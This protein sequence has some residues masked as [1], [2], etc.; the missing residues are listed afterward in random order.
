M[1]SV[2]NTLNNALKEL[3]DWSSKNNLVCHPKKCKA[4]MLLRGSFPGPI[5]ALT[6][7]NHTIKW[8]THARLLGLTIDDKLTRT[9]HISEAKKSFLTN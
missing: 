6:L 2:T 1:D 8:V 4:M 5:H 9:Q 7:C 3:E